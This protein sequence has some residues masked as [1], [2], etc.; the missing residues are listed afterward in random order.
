MEAVGR[1]CGISWGQGGHTLERAVE[2]G[3]ARKPRRL[4]IRLGVDEKSLTRGPASLEA[5]WRQFSQ[6]ERAQVE[7]VAMDL[8]DPYIAATKA[9]VP[10]AE[11]R[12]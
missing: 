11:S 3:R 1:L 7:A 9:C 10:Q 2:R 5:Y 4:P 8:W 6:E 12:P